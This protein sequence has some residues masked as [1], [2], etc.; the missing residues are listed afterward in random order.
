[1]NLSDT[2][3]KNHLKK[4]IMNKLVNKVF[5]TVFTLFLLATIVAGISWLFDSKPDNLYSVWEFLRNCVL[6]SL[7]FFILFGGRKN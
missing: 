5:G 1:M 6:V 2:L 3:E 7:L 4:V